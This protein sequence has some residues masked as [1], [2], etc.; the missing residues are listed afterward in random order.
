MRVR[1]GMVSQI[2]PGGVAGVDQTGAGT[3]ISI[4]SPLNNNGIRDVL[5][6]FLGVITGSAA[7]SPGQAFR[8][9]YA[10]SEAEFK[11]DS[12]DVMGTPSHYRSGT[13]SQDY[14]LNMY[15][16]F[17]NAQ[18]QAGVDVQGDDYPDGFALRPIGGAGTDNTHKYDV[19]VWIYEVV[20]T[21]GAVQ[22]WFDKVNSHDGTCDE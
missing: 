9:K 17:N 20:N 5:D 7:F 6:I 10:W 13:T 15:E 8:W 1:V 3:A 11:S 12:I 18:Y 22:Y 16:V 19:P 14:L 4:P 21:V 2:A